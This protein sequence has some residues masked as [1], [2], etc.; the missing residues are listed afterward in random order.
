MCFG[1]PKQKYYYHVEVIPDRHY[2]Y[3]H[4]HSHAPRSSYS[5]HHPHQSLR[6]LRSGYHEMGDEAAEAAKSG[7]KLGRQSCHLMTTYVIYFTR[8]KS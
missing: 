5:P 4:H 7:T 2:P 6:T 8:I 3:H 1:P